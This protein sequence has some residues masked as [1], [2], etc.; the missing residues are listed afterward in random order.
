MGDRPFRSRASYEAE[1][2]TWA[3]LPSYLQ[4]RGFVVEQDIRE[5]QGQTIV[6]V[7]PEGERLAARVRLCWREESDDHEPHYA[8]AQLLSRIKGNNWE[9]TLEE[10]VARE[11][12]R[13]VSHF[14][15]AQRSEHDIRRAALVP[16]SELVGIWVE[17]RDI[18]S[19][20]IRDG[21][22]GKR[23]KNHAMNGSSPTIW[24]KD[25]RGGEEVANALWNH[26]G[27][28]DIGQMALSNSPPMLPEEIP[29][30]QRYIEGACQR[31]WVNSYER[32]GEARQRCIDHYGAACFICGFDFGAAYGDTA[33]GFI[34]VHHLRPLASVGREYEVN[35]VKDMCPVCP[36]C[37][38]VIHIGGGCR[39]IDEVKR[40]VVERRQLHKNE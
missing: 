4:R 27:V 18:S 19:R 40:L 28:R 33:A 36:N 25:D 16:V 7:S 2:R 15:F 8:A 20:L 29:D 3:I 10:K 11:R 6:A 17:Q 26:P 35:P 23:T 12:A 22:L 13:G 14:L 5:R 38:A 30:P 21:K 37:H 24:L 1:E 9:G 34:H 31:V 39:H 32:D